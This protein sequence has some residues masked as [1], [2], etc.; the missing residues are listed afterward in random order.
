MLFT[1]GKITEL[2]NR[3]MDENTYFLY[4]QEVDFSK[5]NQQIASFKAYFVPIVKT[6]SKL[7]GGEK[8]TW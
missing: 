6:L 7:T 2:S 1:T 5:K 3:D 4:F 8:C